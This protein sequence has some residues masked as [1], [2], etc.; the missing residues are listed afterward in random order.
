MRKIISIALLLVA[1]LIKSQNEADSL[2]L[3][4]KNYTKQDSIRVELLVDAC[5]G[6]I[7]KADTQLLAYASE[8]Y[9]ISNKTNYRLGKIRS[10]NCIGNYYYQRAAFDKAIDYYTKALSL[11]EKDKDEKNIIISKSNIANVYTHTQKQSKAIPLYKECDGIL[12]KNGDSLSQ[13]RAAILTNLAT[14]YSSTNHHDSAI[15]I[16]NK[17]FDICTKK[18]IVFGLG[19]TLSNLSSEYYQIGSYSQAISSCEKALKLIEEN[20][21]DFIKVNVYKSLGSTYVALKQFDKGIEF[22]NKGKEFAK[23]MTDQENLVEL[24]GKLYKAYFQINDFKNAYLNSIDYINLKDTIF[25]IEKEKAITEINT[26]YET[27]KKEAAIKELTQE[28]TISDLQSQ[29][30]SVLIYSILGAIVALVVLSYFLFTRYKAKKQNEL[31]KIKLEE[32]EKII[33]A[34]KKAAESELKALKSQMNPHFIFNALNS[35]QEQFMYGDKL[36]GNEQLGNFTY[37]T[38]QILTVSGKKQIPLSTEIEILNKYL[39]LEKMRFQNDFEYNVSFSNK[40]DEDYTQLPPMLIQPFVENSIKHGLLHKEGFKKLSV[41]FDISEGEE[42][43]IC[44]VT[45][46]GIGRKKAAEINAGKTTKHASFSTGS[47]EQR[48]ELLNNNLKQN[49][50]ITYEDLLDNHGQCEG[51]RVVIK[52]P[53][54]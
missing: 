22:L 42:Y 14:A 5:V 36:K 11:S 37:L 49:N 34:E 41:Y 7:F 24:Y 17:V 2:L 8:A 18:N 39:E 47:I 53:L 3:K 46:N 48:L 26:K 10:N 9:D 31:L 21:M 35:I 32:A 30:K 51:T 54:M 15:Y 27:E 20:H 13:N 33:D 19:I 25:G 40:I 43:L 6:G 12:L 45:D 16:Y 23:Q 44:T 38:R 52:I 4:I 1:G 50:M 28:K 29:Q